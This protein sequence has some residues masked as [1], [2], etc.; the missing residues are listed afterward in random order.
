MESNPV[1]LAAQSSQSC[2]NSITKVVRTRLPDDFK[3]NGYTVLC[4]QGKEYFNNVGNRRFRV[5][6]SMYLERYSLSETKT[7]KSAIVTDVMSIMRGAGGGFCKLDKRIWYEVGDVAAREKVGSY[8]RDCL[9]MQYRSSAKSKTARRRKSR[10][11]QQDGSVYDDDD[12]SV[13]TEPIPTLSSSY[14]FIPCAPPM[15][16]PD[17][18]RYSA[19]AISTAMPDAITSFTDPI[20]PVREPR[21]SDVLGTGSECFLMLEDLED[22]ASFSM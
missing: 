6:V 5:I 1:P 8:F 9:H 11:L 14:S 2:Q 16:T 18:R 15:V 20:A 22:D 10:K 4:G 12:S 3:P 7:E 19:P 17:R 13:V 21:L